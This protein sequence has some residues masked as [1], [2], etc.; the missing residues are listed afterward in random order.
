MSKYFYLD[1]LAAVGA[2]LNSYYTSEV[3]FYLVPQTYV[4]TMLAVAI[5]V[6]C[7]VCSFN[8]EWDTNSI[9]LCLHLEYWEQK[10]QL[11]VADGNPPSHNL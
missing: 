3:K 1:E 2:V 8:S 5:S 10:Q 11:I 6:P 9:S 4:L 7:N